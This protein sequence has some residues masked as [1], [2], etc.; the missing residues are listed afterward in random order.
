M[1]DKNNFVE[2]NG[3]SVII[4]VCSKCNIKCEHR[5]IS[6]KGNRNSKELV[7]LVKHLKNKYKIKINRSTLWMKK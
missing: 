3:E 2:Y 5:Y 4:M 6:Y 1:T 7:D